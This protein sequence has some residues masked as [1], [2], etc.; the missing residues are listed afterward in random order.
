MYLLSQLLLL[1]ASA[2]HAKEVLICQ[3]WIYKFTTASRNE[4]S[5]TGED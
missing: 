3:K 1:S 5:D 4:K 2:S